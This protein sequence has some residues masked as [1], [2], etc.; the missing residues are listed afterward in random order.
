MEQGDER[1]DVSHLDPQTARR[2]DDERRRGGRLGAD[3]D[4]SEGR[5][6]ERGRGHPAAQGWEM[7]RER[8][9]DGGQGDVARELLRGVLADLVAKRFRIGPARAEAG[10]G[11][12]ATAQCGAQGVCL[13]YT[14]D[15]ADE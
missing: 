5:L 8:R 15:A 7:E 1:F 9:G 14:S 3:H 12:E 6:R 10:R 13:L 4:R 2:M 11:G